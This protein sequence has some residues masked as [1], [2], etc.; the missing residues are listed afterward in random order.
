M[1]TPELLRQY[2]VVVIGKS[3]TMTHANE[4]RWMVKGT[5]EVCEPE[6]KAFI[7]EDGRVMF[8]H[9]ANGVTKDHSPEWC[10][11]TGNSFLGHPERCEVRIRITGNHPI[12]EGCEG[13]AERDEH[14]QLEYL[15][16]DMNVFLRSASDYA[17]E[18]I[19]GYTRTLGKGKI[20]V[21]IP[22]HNL[23]VFRNAQ[24]RKLFLNALRWCAD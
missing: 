11:L 9:A 21:F 20:C 12:T 14:Y 8:F 15:T 16:D 1:L 7:E 18:Q 22:G 4:S 17:K 2:D 10:E 23:G 6:L 5:A 19:A 13:F 3:N 24:F